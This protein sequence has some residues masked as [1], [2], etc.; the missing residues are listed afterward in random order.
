M[1]AMPG[2]PTQGLDLVAGR[3]L[4]EESVELRIRLRPGDRPL[5]IEGEPVAAGAP[6]V[7]RLRDPRTEIL[8]ARSSVPDAARPGDRW[9]MVPGRL[10]EPD[11]APGELLFASHGRWRVALGDHAES[12][13]APV[14]G[15][16]SI[17]RA[18][19]E[20][21]LA[22]GARAVPGREVLGGPTVGRLEVIAARDAEVRA[23]DLDVDLAGAIV[24]AGARIDAEAITRARAVGV[25]GIVVGS[26]GTR[27]RRDAMATDARGRAAVHG[28][29]PFA[30]LVLEGSLRLPIP[31]ATMAVLEALEGRTVSLV[32]GPP[33]L[34]FDAPSLALPIPEPG[35]VRVRGGTAAGLEGTFVG[36]AGLRQAEPGVLVEMAWVRIGGRDP[37][38]LPLGD[39][40]RF[41]I[42]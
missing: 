16:A 35:L 32:A 30:I 28:L 18:G 22:T 33:A 34:V 19:V 29:P 11:S 26:L 4:V 2:D 36:L 3:P 13:E 37:V 42:R 25:R 7:E 12:I 5:V 31:S 10:A 39:L 21:R 6:I 15:L 23:S 24:V 8:P 17:V 41:V 38:A 9:S 40:D 1:T 14:A 27:E 20:L